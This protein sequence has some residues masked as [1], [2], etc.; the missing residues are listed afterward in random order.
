MGYNNNENKSNFVSV[1]IPTH[2]RS[3][4][5]KRAVKSV[6]SQT[7]QN[8]EVIVVS[9][10]SVDDTDKV[11]NDICEQ[12]SRVKYISYFPAQGGNIARNRGIENAQYKYIA[13][14]DDDDEWHSDKLEKQI[15][16]FQQN[17]N[18]GLVCTG[19]NAIYVKENITISYIPTAPI[20]SSREIL[21]KN[22]IGSTTTV[23]IKSELLKTCG[24]FDPELK[25]LQDY[26][27]WIRICQETMVGVVR[28]PCVDYYNDLGN[29][30]ISQ[31][32]GKYIEATKHINR[33]YSRLLSTL[34]KRE[35]KQRN[36][37]FSLLIAKKGLRN[38]DKKVARKYA[39]NALK[40]K[41]SFNPIMI[42][43]ASF[44]PYKF[45]LLI[46]M[47]LQNQ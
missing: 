24:K 11:M 33:K 37:V 16:L 12:D 18:I 8:F 6:L 9:D 47:H 32:T 41:V 26:D 25:A 43:I 2:N 17:K 13:F 44:F 10:G 38:G 22:C 3:H 15:N 34:S 20:D 21:I 31:Y 7:F 30:Q 5:I 23:M 40:I 1:V 35:H 28:E 19:I 45:L 46:K 39:L 14:L 27:L 36:I 4:L 29:D 42:F